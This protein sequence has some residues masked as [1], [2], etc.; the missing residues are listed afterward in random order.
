MHRQATE[1]EENIPSYSSDKGLI[2]RMYKG[3]KKLNS[4]RRDN[5]INKWTN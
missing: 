5:L 1:W 4:K 3:L 2:S